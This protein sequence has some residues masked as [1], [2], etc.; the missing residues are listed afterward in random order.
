[1]GRFEESVDIIRRCWTGERFSFSGKSID[2]V[3]FDEAWSQ[4]QIIEVEEQI[5]SV[6]SR[7]QL[8]QNKKASGQRKDLADVAWLESEAPRSNETRRS[9]FRYS[10]NQKPSPRLWLST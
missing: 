8:L 3:E 9:G 5:F 1:V 2:G 10:V 4:R 6:I 7:V